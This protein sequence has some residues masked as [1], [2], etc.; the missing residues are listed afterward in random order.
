MLSAYTSSNSLDPAMWAAPNNV[1]ASTRECHNLRK[2]CGRCNG[3]GRKLWFMP[4]A[5]FSEL[6]AGNVIAPK[7]WSMMHVS[8]GGG[9]D[10]SS[11]HIGTSLWTVRPRYNL[12]TET[13]AHFLGRLI[14]SGSDA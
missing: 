11:P 3:S 4:G 5:E 6:R 1:V 12:R 14:V 7:P 13:K 10:C 8:Y 2:A 9:W